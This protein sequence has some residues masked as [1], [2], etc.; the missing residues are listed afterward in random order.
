MTKRQGNRDLDLT[1]CVIDGNADDVRQKLAGGL[2]PD[3]REEED[4]PTPLIVAAA[5]RSGKISCGD[6]ARTCHGC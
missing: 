1:R 3:I 5:C 2:D 6:D 4:D